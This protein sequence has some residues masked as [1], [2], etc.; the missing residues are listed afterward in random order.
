MDD[1]LQNAFERA[2]EL[3]DKSQYIIIT[4]HVNPD[5]DAIGSALAMHEY[6]LAKG[7]KSHIIIDSKVPYNLNF[8]HGSNLIE[9]FNP[10][11]SYEKFLSADLIIILDLNDPARTRSMSEYLMNSRAS[12]ILIDHHVK[13]KKFAD[14]MITDT[15]AA[16]TGELVAQFISMDPAYKMT[17][18][19]AEDLYV[20]IMTDTG[21]FRFPKTTSSLHRLIA[22]LI[23]SGASP[24]Y[25][26][27]MV[28]NRV[29]EGTLRVL[30]E[31]YKNLE[32]YHNGQVCA[33]I[34]TAKMFERTGTGEEHLEGFVER[35]LAIEGVK[36]GVLFK[37]LSTRGE[38][39]VSF[40]SKDDYDVRS[41][42]QKLGGGGHT[43]AAGARVGNRPLSEVKSMIVGE[44]GNIL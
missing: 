28:Y 8:L 10:T 6:C 1:K 17:K 16:A 12:K 19:V 23:D 41:V 5:G 2:R 36:V 37:E 43:N 13:P 26:Y 11:S 14:A 24:H 25:L 42:A 39:A 15:E 4:T 34:V 35:T 30:G 9:E 32:L 22:D 3:F 18:E 7:K 31:A 40:R 27:E 33:M 38:V 20:A 29:T 21:S 44:L